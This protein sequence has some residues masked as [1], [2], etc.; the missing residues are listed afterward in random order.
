M[1]GSKVGLADL[2]LLKVPYLL[3]VLLHSPITAE[4]ANPQS[5]Q[6]R[7]P[8]PLRP[9]LISGI[10]LLL[11]LDVGLEIGSHQLPIIIVRYHRHYLQHDVL[12][13]KY[14]R[15]DGIDHLFKLRRNIVVGIRCKHLT[16][17]IIDLVH[18][19][20]ED[21]DILGTHFLQDF[22]VGTIHRAEKQSTI[23]RKFH[24][25]GP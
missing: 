14:P 5:T 21:E 9:I 18:T 19:S 10:N 12:L 25:A 23:H 20:S 3:R 11:S 15:P 8:G 22:Y 4:F 13:C 6:N 1:D 7:H 17:Q 24:I 16:S 2:Y